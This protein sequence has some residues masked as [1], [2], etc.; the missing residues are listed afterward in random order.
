VHFYV[1]EAL[2]MINRAINKR[3]SAGPEPA[4]LLPP[5]PPLEDTQQGAAEG[6]ATS[7]GLLAA[8]AMGELTSQ[9]NLM[10]DDAEEPSRKRKR[11]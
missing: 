2:A 9:S 1:Q 8:A 10:P 7:M 5:V 4:S 11:G 3:Q 6:D